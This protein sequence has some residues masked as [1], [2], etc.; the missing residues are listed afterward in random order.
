MSETLAF[1]YPI[2]EY[3]TEPFWQ[4]C[5]DGKLVMQQCDDCGKYRW[6]PAPLCLQCRAD[7]FTW[8]PLSGRGKIITWTVVTHPIHP[9]AVSKVPY[10]VVIIE[11]EEQEGLR[12]VSN[13]IDV[14]VDTI[15]FDGLVSV[16]FEE[17]PSGQKLPVFR[18]LAK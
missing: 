8:A 18:L 12:M 7:G 17:H 4:A 11:L 5:N 10:V 6:T 15:E 3:G 9:A 13:L 1:P 14:D 16:D 2:P